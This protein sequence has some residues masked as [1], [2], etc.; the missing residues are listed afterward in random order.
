MQFV[1]VVPSA[2]LN[3]QKSTVI[4]QHLGLLPETVSKAGAFVPSNLLQVLPHPLP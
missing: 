3:Q 1:P 4:G 2:V